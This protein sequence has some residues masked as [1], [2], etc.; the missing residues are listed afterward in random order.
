MKPGFLTSEFWTSAGTVLGTLITVGVTVGVITPA[1]GQ[2]L[3]A[4]VTSGLAAAAAFA[5]NAYVVVQYIQNRTALK[6]GK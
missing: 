6:Q 5:T 2:N 4:A 1:D 3:A